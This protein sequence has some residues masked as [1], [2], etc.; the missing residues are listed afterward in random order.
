MPEPSHSLGLT[1]PGVAEHVAHE[2][3][4]GAFSHDPDPLQNPVFPQIG[5]GSHSSSGSAPGAIDPHA[6]STPPPFFVPV[7]ASHTP[8]QSWSQQTPST[9]F[10]ERQSAASVQIAPSMRFI[11]VLT[12]VDELAT[13]LE[14][15]D[16]A[17]A[18]DDDALA[19][20]DDALVLDVAPPTPV[21]ELPGAPPEPVELLA[22]ED[23]LE[24]AAPPTAEPLLSGRTLHDGPGGSRSSS[25]LHAAA[26]S[27]AAPTIPALRIHALCIAALPL[28]RSRARWRFASY[29]TAASDGALLVP[30]SALQRRP[31][32]K[33]SRIAMNQ[34]N[35]DAAH[36]PA[37]HAA[38]TPSTPADPGAPTAPPAS[39]DT[40]P[41]KALL[42]FMVQEWGAAPV[43]PSDP[44]PGHEAFER[45]RRALS[46][47][48]PGETLVIPT[49]HEKVRSNDTHYRF[50]PGTDFY[51]LTGNLEPDCVLVMLPID[52]GH[53]DVLY[54]EPNPGRGDATFFT[55]RI[56]GEL[57][58]GPR[59]GVPES[60]GRFGVHACRGIPDLKPFL[61]TLADD[62]AQKPVVLRGFSARV[63]G[64]LPAGDRDKQLAAALSEMRLIKD[65]AEIAELR[66]VIDSTK[67]GFEDV[68]R[69]LRKATSER[70]VEGVFNLRA[71]IE[72]NDVGYGTIAASGPHA[73]VLHWT[74]NNGTLHRGE[75]LLLDAGVEGNSLYTA[76]ITRTLPI[77]GRFSKEQRKIYKLV[78]RAQKA[79][80]KRV[81]PG[82]DFMDPNKAAM[83]V[84][85]EGLE[86]L[87]ILRT[88][89]AEA[90]KEEH[91]FYKRY[92]LHN[93][94]HML[95]LDVHDCAQ[96]RNEVYKFG[97]LQVGMV[98]TVE[99]G[100]YFQENDL[101][102][103]EAYRGIGVRI[104]DDIVVTKG[105]YDNLSSHIPSQADDVEEWIATVW[106]GKK[107]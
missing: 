44:L 58:V 16:E 97:K 7:Q 87:G 14:A 24:L 50:R 57:W 11:I 84:L 53:T 13:L 38:E 103:P 102:V 45:R 86:S 83:K 88:T 72:G 35:D 79:A 80:F 62:A 52:G 59:L 69:S 17:L 66:A 27:A 68:I 20:D 67:R 73:C 22:V 71:R 9:Q 49:G 2:V 5:A 63:D 18:L 19:L 78:Y 42:D 48:F 28:V 101:T 61:E 8:L 26:R 39:H 77:K 65:E 81:K 47:L 105:G 56:K 46:K 25:T 43:S 93:V 99:P 74:K 60:L 106:K 37:A 64:A 31:I 104:E 98:L 85:A 3:A 100:L 55:D 54:V 21:V 15:D 70:E 96:A 92:S 91:Q 6:P 107:R 23:V 1:K 51:Y 90:L 10:I 36:A 4:A 95:G 30:E 82:N 34:L 76:D 12:P 75:L 33:V 94:S 29:T 40:P 41:P 32:G 89:A